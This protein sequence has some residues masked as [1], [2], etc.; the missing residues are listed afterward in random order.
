MVIMHY[1]KILL[2]MILGVILAH[3]YLA[4]VL[5]LFQWTTG[6]PFMTRKEQIEIEEKSGGRIQFW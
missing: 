6:S 4:I 3:L 2:S 5:L 1:I